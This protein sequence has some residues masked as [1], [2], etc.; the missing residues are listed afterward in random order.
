MSRK[1][2]VSEILTASGI[3]VPLEYTLTEQASL[4]QCNR[5]LAQA[6]RG[7]SLQI[8]FPACHSLSLY[9]INKLPAINTLV[10]M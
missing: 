4:D 8:D 5:L 1:T 10:A 2:L 7:F 3:I 6:L 9:P